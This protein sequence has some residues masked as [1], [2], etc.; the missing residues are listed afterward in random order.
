MKELHLYDLDFTL[1]KMPS[2]LAVIDKREPE[3]IIYRIPYDNIALMKS[4]Y[5]KYDLKVEYNGNVWYLSEKMWNDITK[6]KDIK[7]ND[8]G[9]SD[10]EW[11]DEEI[12][13]SQISKTEYLLD[14]LKH[15]KNKEI[16]LG[17]LTARSR[18]K[19]HKENIDVLK[20]KIDLKLNL[21][22]KK[23]YFINNIDDNDDTDITSNRKA[24]IILEHLVG[25]KTKGNRFIDL[26]QDKYDKVY[27]YD[28]NDKNIEQASALQ[29]LLEKL[30]IKTNKEIKHDILE[31]IKRTDLFYIVNK[32]TDN[33]TNPFIKYERKLLTPNNIT[34]FEQF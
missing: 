11:K 6:I 29:F 28:D 18:E 24:K 19:S 20:Q 31:R 22:I 27:F 33:K 34:L 16:D 14:N 30:L 1:W 10:R 2:K 21:P 13:E 26:K 5:K 17:V 7:I 15:L 32:I 8:I 4:Y 23:I 25:Y 3:K 12:L 9:I